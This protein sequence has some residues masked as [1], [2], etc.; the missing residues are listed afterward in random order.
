MYIS[1][2][3][4]IKGD[5]ITNEELA[6]SPKPK[7]F[8]DILREIIKISLPVGFGAIVMNL[9]GV[10]DSVL[11]QR[12]LA[13]VAANSLDKLKNIYGAFIPQEAL[14]RNNVH[15]FL[16]GCFGFTSTIAMFL[17]TIAM[18][19]AVS[20]LP[21][22]TTAWTLGD[23]KNIRKSIEKIL[24]I[25]SIISIPMGFGISSLALPILDLIYN[26]LHSGEHVGEIYIG[27]QIMA[28]SGIGAIFIAFSMPVCSMLQA[29][30]R[31]DLPLKILSIGVLIKILLNYI[32]VGIPEINIQGAA[33]GTLVCYIFVFTLSLIALCRNAKIKI[34]F[35]SIFIKPCIAG[36]VCA[37]SANLFYKILYKIINLKL[38][39]ILSIILSAIVYFIM[40]F[41]LKIITKQEL[42]SDR[43]TKK[44]S[45]IFKKLKFI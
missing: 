26:T 25:T 22:V 34:N 33:V 41:L 23:K 31:A 8:R 7:R 3:Y 29:I 43:R 35:M 36:I 39:T 37:F 44:F 2:R 28:V 32:L 19:L 42:E 38:A 5:S 14:I 12:R 20:T 13:F 27:S 11:I 24:K 6:H 17:P 10:I 16:S 4:K 40:I 1:I 30:G 21:S 15:L 18:G 9:A 45:K